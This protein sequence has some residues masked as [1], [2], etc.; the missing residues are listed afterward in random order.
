MKFKAIVAM[1]IIIVI[2]GGIG[3]YF[4]W[5]KVKE[6]KF[7]STN[8]KTKAAYEIILRREAQIRKEKNNYDAY[9]SLGFN[10]KGIGEVTKTDEYLK[11]AVEVYNQVIKRWG[12]TAYLPFVNRANVY[13]ELKEY[14]RAE[15]DLKIALEIDP[16]EQNL[17]V[18][19]ADLYR[20]YMNKDGKM[21]KSVYEQGLKTVVGGGNLV[22][23]Y[24]GYLKE[25]GEY[26]ESLKYYKMLKQAY[27]D[28]TSYDE[29]IRELEAKLPKT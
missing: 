2:G 17:Y 6:Y 9:M 29:V 16:G 1:A 18:S 4:Y 11:R 7:L 26:K 20:T 14:A 27:P 19:L 10:W 15:D 12:T 23:N 22:L 8:L 28:S 13:I 3:G 24:A 25:T 5:Q 21:I